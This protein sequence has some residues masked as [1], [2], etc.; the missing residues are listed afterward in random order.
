MVREKGW[1]GKE[2]RKRLLDAAAEEFA[3][4]GF[5]DTKVSTIVKQAGFTQPSFYLYFPSKEAVFEEIVQEF[6]SDLGELTASLRLEPG[7]EPEELLKRVM[8]ALEKIFR[9]LVRNPHKTRIGLFL[10]PQAE[11]IKEALTAHLLE[12]LRAEQAAGYFRSDVEMA[13]VAECL[14]GMIERLTATYLL[15]GKKTPAELAK[16]VV[17]VLMYGMLPREKQAGQSNKWEE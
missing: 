4:R 12:N 11:Q 17:D 1:K 10:A 8:Q 13:T 7:I 2:S 6:Q 3:L 9:F 16:Q 14:I 5:H 15:P